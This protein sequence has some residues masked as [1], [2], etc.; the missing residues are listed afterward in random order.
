MSFVLFRCGLYVYFQGVLYFLYGAL[1]IFILSI[2]WDGMTESTILYKTYCLSSWSFRLGAQILDFGKPMGVSAYQNG[3]PKHSSGVKSKT[4][5]FGAP[6]TSRWRVSGCCGVSFYRF[7]AISKQLWHAFWVGW[8]V[9]F[10]PIILGKRTLQ[11]PYLFND[12]Q[13]RA[14]ANPFHFW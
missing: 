4:S 5:V 7:P 10:F 14:S 3:S 13:G 11:F 12:I 8:H 9:Y 2:G 6:E 1:G